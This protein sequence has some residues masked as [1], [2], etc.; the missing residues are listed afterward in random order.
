MDRLREFVLENGVRGAC[1][2]GL[3]CDAPPDPKK[4][5]PDGHTVNLTFFKVALRTHGDSSVLSEQMK[6]LVEDEVPALLDGKEH[7]Y[8]QIGADIG[9][10]GLALTLIGVGH[11]L[12]L[13]AAL[14]PDTLLPEAPEGL[15]K[16]MAASGMVS[17]MTP[18]RGKK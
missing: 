3:C 1:T 13:W 8:I 9:D 6:E 15:K 16:Q 2:C 10:Q 18:K 7:S 4:Q 12:G 5:Q 17:L 14:S 11:L